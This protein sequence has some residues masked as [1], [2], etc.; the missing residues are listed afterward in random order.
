MTEK[1]KL[2]VFRICDLPS[3]ERPRERLL[4]LGPA[5]LSNEE[6]LALLLRTGI[7]GESA[8]DRARSLLATRGGLI[9]LS[10]VSPEELAS[11][12]GIGPTRAAAIAA[13]I[14]IARR[15]PAETLSGRDLLNEPRLVK[16]FLRQAQADDTQERTGALYLN[17]RNRLLKNDPEI[18]RGTLDR[19]VVEPREIL[20]RA[21]LGKAAGLILYHNH[22]SGDPTPSREDREFTR[23]LAA[24]A[25][26]IGVRLLDHIV[27]GREG[28]V[29]FR[30][31]GLL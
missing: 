15:L 21:L 31:A 4:R 12:R 25:E 5:A 7:P 11:E 27:V 22:P 2:R 18:Y 16:E 24:A 26:S 14:E 3:E 20:R 28:C 17:A 10:G 29:S 30:E 13:A 19:A 23:R 8:L 9:G 6:L 1:S